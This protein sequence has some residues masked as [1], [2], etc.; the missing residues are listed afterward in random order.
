MNRLHRISA[1]NPIEIRQIRAIEVAADILEG[2][3]G[4]QDRGLSLQVQRQTGWAGADAWHAGLYVYASSKKDKEKLIKI[5]LRNLGGA[6]LA[7]IIEVLGH[8][9]RHAFQHATGLQK[10]SSY[11]L[12]WCGEIYNDQVLG[13]D[14][15]YYRKWFHNPAEIDARMFQKPYAEIVFNHPKFAE[16]VPYLGESFGEV[17]LRESREANYKATGFSKEEVQLVC[18]RE[19]KQNTYWF[20]LSQLNERLEKPV[21]KITSKYI[22][23]MFSEHRDFLKSQLFNKHYVELSIE[24][25]VS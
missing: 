11:H 5:N 4:L 21:K 18:F 1:R 24:D 12:K 8:E 3:L 25:L 20:S 22:Q 15:D 7:M 6:S 2:V 14:A 23:F 13:V 9:F 10:V 16:F 19:D 17:P